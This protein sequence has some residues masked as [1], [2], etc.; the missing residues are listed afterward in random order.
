VEGNP[1]D[2][3]GESGVQ[4]RPTSPWAFLWLGKSIQ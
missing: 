1:E 3:Q 2:I 4:S